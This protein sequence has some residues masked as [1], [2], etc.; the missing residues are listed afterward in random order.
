[1]DLRALKTAGAM[2]LYAG[3]AGNLL[4]GN[5]RSPHNGGG[6]PRTFHVKE[7]QMTLSNLSLGLCALVCTAILAS[8]A[9]SQASGLAA[10]AC[11]ECEPGLA[12]VA[13]SEQVATSLPGD[14]TLV[15]SAGESHSMTDIKTDSDG[16]ITEFET[17]LVTYKWNGTEKRYNPTTIEMSYFEFERL[18]PGRYKWVKRNAGGTALDQGSLDC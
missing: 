5:R 7:K 8:F 6:G 15:N 11:A 13:A 4:H 16:Y 17:G 1:V 9:Q 14:L 3:C 18:S 10:P 2:Q 12:V